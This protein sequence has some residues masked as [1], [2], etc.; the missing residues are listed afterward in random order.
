[1]SRG[2]VV[3]TLHLWPPLGH[4][5]HYTGTT[6]ERRLARRLTDHAL[7]RGARLTQV[8]IE[9]GGSWV[10]AQTQPGGRTLE[11]RLKQHGA[12]RR[13][14]VCKAVSGYQAGDLPAADALGR[15]G[16]DRSNPVQR[17]MLL[18]IFGLPEPPA[19]AADPAPAASTAPEPEA[20]HSFIPAPRLPGEPE[21]LAV[22]ASRPRPTRRWRPRCGAGA[23]LAGPRADRRGHR[24][25]PN[26]RP[27]VNPTQTRPTRPELEAH[28]MTGP[29]PSTMPDQ[30]SDPALFEPLS[31]DENKILSA[32]LTSGWYKQAA[33]YPMLSEPWQ[34][35]AGLL[36]DLHDAWNAAFEARK[37]PGASRARQA[38]GGAVTAPQA[39]EGPGVVRVRLSGQSGAPE[40]LAALLG[41]LPGCGDPDRP[42]WPV[43][44]PAPARAPALPHRP[45]HRGPGPGR[46]GPLMATPAE[47]L[48]AYEAA[49]AERRSFGA[50]PEH[51]KAGLPEAVERANAAHAAWHAALREPE[52]GG[53]L[54]VTIDRIQ[55]DARVVDGMTREF[56]P[57]RVARSPAADGA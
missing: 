50:K 11:R 5:A 18:D 25:N 6:P 27:L 26:W 40:D 14:E 37:Q 31:L 22:A 42:G 48:K 23:E 53:G 28:R 52:L 51:L 39:A 7:G 35:T 30:P 43:P 46:R 36:D 45:A 34:E 16:W 13:C 4:A 47:L 15:A 21:P 2:Q 19:G 32:H 17:S 57:S 12:T 20:W 24:R 33:V 44:E 1:M 56:D 38:E 49:D 9:R 55:L 29:E 3:Y 10:L 41:G 8:Q 54:T